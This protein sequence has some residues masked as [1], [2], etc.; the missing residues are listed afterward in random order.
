MSAAHPWAAGTRILSA[1]GQGHE[2]TVGLSARDRRDFPGWPPHGTLGTV[3]DGGLIGNGSLGVKRYYRV[4]FDGHN[5]NYMGGQHSF[6]VTD[7]MIE[8]APCQ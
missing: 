2:G 4:T 6:M 7:E 3:I 8:R 5:K 1:D